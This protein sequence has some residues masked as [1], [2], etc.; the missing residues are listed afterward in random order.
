M[1]QWE[2]GQKAA[3]RALFGRPLRLCLGV[4]LAGRS[5]QDFFQREA[6]DAMR[7]WEPAHSAVLAELRKF[8]EL[9]LLR[10]LEPTADDRRVWYSRTDSRLWRVFAGAGEA[11]GLTVDQAGELHLLPAEQDESPPT[12]RGPRTAG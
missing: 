8:V 5:S 3:A 6:V 9:G 10:R 2:A 11:F 7:P 4:W 12:G 1:E